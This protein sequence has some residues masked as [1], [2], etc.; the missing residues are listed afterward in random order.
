[1]KKGFTLIEMVVII[2]IISILA[3]IIL[4]PLSKVKTRET[5]GKNAENT[6]NKI[7]LERR[8]SPQDH[9]EFSINHVK[10]EAEEAEKEKYNLKKLFEVD[11]YS[12]Y[13]A[14]DNCKAFYF[15]IP[16]PTK[17]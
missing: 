12:V 2:C 10:V 14:Y 15:T 1:M 5:N 9:N 8:D 17:H 6:I 11:G 3:A 16:T 13:K 4:L 7:E